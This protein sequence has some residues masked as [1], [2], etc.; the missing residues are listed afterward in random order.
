MNDYSSVPDSLS[1]SCVF[2]KGPGCPGHI[3]TEHPVFPGPPHPPDQNQNRLIIYPP[4]IAGT[5]GAAFCVSHAGAPQVK[6][7]R[8]RRT[9]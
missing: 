4:T 6:H 8:R 7:T 2:K 5:S 1:S 3:M 9:I